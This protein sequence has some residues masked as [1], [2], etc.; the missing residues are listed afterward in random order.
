MWQEIIRKIEFQSILVLLI[1]LLI[2]LGL[3]HLSN[4]FDTPAGILGMISIAFG[5]LYTFGSF[6]TNQIRE[7]YQDVIREYKSTIQTLRTSHKDIEQSY[8]TMNN[9]SNDQTIGGYRALE[10]DDRRTQSD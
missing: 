8:K 4:R 6:F 1:T 3:L 5:L 7:S 2:G 10:D 9:S